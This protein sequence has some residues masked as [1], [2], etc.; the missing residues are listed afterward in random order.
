LAALLIIQAA[1]SDRDRY[2]RYQEKV[3]P[4]VESCG[5]RLRATG[6]NLEV[7]EGR[8]DGRRLMV[9]EFASMDALQA[10]WH[11]PEYADIKPLRAGAAKVEVWAVPAQ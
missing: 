3:Q 7:L 9:F 5:G 8:R 6:V 2:R 1:V 10:F 11:S 4:L